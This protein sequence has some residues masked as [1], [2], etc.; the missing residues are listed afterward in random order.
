MPVVM[1]TKQLADICDPKRAY[2]GEALTELL[3]VARLRTCPAS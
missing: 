1:T 3:D 2:L